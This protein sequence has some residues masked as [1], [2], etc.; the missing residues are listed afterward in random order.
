MRH[1]NAMRL[2]WVA[3]SVVVVTNV[4]YKYIVNI[5][6]EPRSWINFLAALKVK[7]CD[8]LK[9]LNMLRLLPFRIYCKI[10]RAGTRAPARTLFIEMH[11]LLPS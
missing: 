3:L 5:M 1:S 2:H 7:H 6:S 8:Y 11:A 10:T 4:A 9:L